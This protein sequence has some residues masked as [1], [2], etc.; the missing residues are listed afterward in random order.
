MSTYYLYAAYYDQRHGTPTI[1]IT[2]HIEQN[3][4]EESSFHNQI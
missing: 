1:R 4:K 2:A 3:E